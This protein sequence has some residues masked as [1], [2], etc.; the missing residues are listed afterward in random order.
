MPHSFPMKSFRLI[1][2]CETAAVKQHFDI[3]AYCENV[4]SRWVNPIVIVL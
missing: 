4:V 2:T 3:I 1:A